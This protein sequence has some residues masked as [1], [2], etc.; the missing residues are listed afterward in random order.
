VFSVTFRRAAPRMVQT[1]FLQCATVV[2]LALELLRNA[3]HSSMSVFGRA[4]CTNH[5]EGF[6]SQKNG[7]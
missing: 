5:T 6:S 7:Q 2:L 4:D 3:S 1:A